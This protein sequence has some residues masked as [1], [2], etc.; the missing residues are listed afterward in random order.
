[1]TIFLLILKYLAIT[2]SSILLAGVSGVIF[3]LLKEEKHKKRSSLPTVL[4]FKKILRF[5]WLILALAALVCV[6]SPIAMFFTDLIS[7]YYVVIIYI[8]SAVIFYL[9]NKNFKKVC[10]KEHDYI[11]SF[12]PAD[13]YQ[14]RAKFTKKRH[15]RKLRKKN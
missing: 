8:A 1:M 2:L 6:I 4:R 3:Q 13:R 12:E 5:K 10:D 15:V 7:P 14:G 11:K 9:T